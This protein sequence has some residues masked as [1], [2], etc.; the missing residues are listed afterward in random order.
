MSCNIDAK[1]SIFF[2]A[3]FFFFFFFLIVLQKQTNQSFITKT[4]MTTTKTSS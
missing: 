1:S 3:F 2:A 4:K